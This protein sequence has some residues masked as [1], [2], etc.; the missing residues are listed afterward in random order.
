MGHYVDLAGRPTWIEDVGSGAETVVLL[1]GGLGNGDELLDGLGPPL[2]Q[3]YRVVAPDRRGH[4]RTADTDAPFHYEEMVDE[5]IAVL[6]QVVGGPAHLVGWSDGGIV[7]LLLSRRRPELVG[8]QVLIGV[9]F[10]FDGM[11]PIEMAE[12]DPFGQ[13]MYEAYVERTPD[14]ADHFPEVLDQGAH[15]VRLRAD[16][17]DG[18][19]ADDRH[20]VARAGRRR[21]LHRPEPH[22][23]A[24]RVPAGGRAGRR[25]GRQ[26]RCADGAAGGG[27]ATGPRLPRRRP[28][29]RHVD[30]GSP[31]LM[32]ATAVALAWR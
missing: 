18:R 31:P 5:T 16:P 29:T 32:A 20:T 28:P 3:R 30:A 4:G 10:H 25:A 2:T 7:A 11:R 21:R 14:G 6:E 8:R 22:G 24:V 17:D 13:A 23:G 1:H 27:G 12:D 19:P 9:N 15:A 26:S